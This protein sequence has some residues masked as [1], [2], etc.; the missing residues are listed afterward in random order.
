MQRTILA[1]CRHVFPRISRKASPLEVLFYFQTPPWQSLPY[2]SS[3]LLWE[4]PPVNS[5]MPALTSTS[6]VCGALHKTDE[7]QRPIP[8]AFWWLPTAMSD[9]WN[10]TQYEV[11]TAGG[12]FTR[13]CVWRKN[14]MSIW[15]FLQEISSMRTSHPENPCTRSCVRYGWIVM[16][17]NRVR[18]RCLAM[19]V[20]ISKGILQ[21]LS[22]SIIG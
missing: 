17:R 11:T 16:A 9:T 5:K 4:R 18:W 20:R 22:T 8:S 1:R 10:E 6:L 3:Y 12:A 14:K 13:L 15:S 19:E 7:V 2:G 21:A